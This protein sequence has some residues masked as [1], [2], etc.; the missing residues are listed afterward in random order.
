M[1]QIDESLYSRQLYVY[2]SDA[3]KTIT[4][5]TVLIH[6]ISGLSIEIAKNL[7][8]SGMNITF[9]DKEQKI[10]IDMIST[11][12]FL[13]EQDIDK[14]IDIIIPKLCELNSN[15]KVSFYKLD[16]II[17]Y[18]LLD[19][20]VYDIII[21]VSQNL[22]LEKINNQYIRTKNKKYI[23]CDSY[24]LFGSIFC[25]FGD[26]FN[27][28]DIDGEEIKSGVINNI[29][30]KIIETI[31]PHNLMTG[32]IIVFDDDINQQQIT[33]I[34]RNQFYV[35]SIKLNANRFTQIKKKEIKS[36]KNLQSSIDNPDINHIDFCNELKGKTI[37]EIYKLKF[38]NTF[39]NYSNY[40]QNSIDKFIEILK[41]NSNVDINLVQK[42]TK[43]L[44][45]NLV[46]INS[47]I[48]SIVAQEAIKACTGKYTPIYQWLHFEASDLLLENNHNIEYSNS[49]Y[50]NQEKIFGNEL[51]KIINNSKIFIVGSGA[52]GCEHLKNFS[53]MGC[54]L[55]VTDMDTI[56][57]SNLSRQF[58]F[59]NNDIGKLKSVVACNKA[60]QMNS[61]INIIAH[62]NKVE[63]NTLHIYNEQ[64]FND[65]TCVTNALDNISARLFVDSLCVMHKKPLI[66]SGTLG[67]KCNIQTII[68]Y[69]TESYGSSSDPP[70]ESIPI[71]TLKNFPYLI[72]HTIQWARELFEGLFTN[73]PLNVI[74]FIHD[75]NFLKN[76][77]SSELVIVVNEIK[78]I[79]SNIPSNFQKC[80]DIACNEFY[81]LFINQTINLLN[82][83]P[84][85]LMIN[86]IPFWSGSKKCPIII[87]FDIN[88][89]NHSNFIIN[90]AFLWA[91]LFNIKIDISDFDIMTYIKDKM[92]LMQFIDSSPL[93]FSANDE[94]EK[95]YQKELEENLNIEELIKSIPPFDSTI[96]IKPIEFEKDDDTNH[97]I[98][99]IT[100][101][102]NL[103]ASIYSIPVIDKFKTKGIAGKIIP[104]I[105]TT[106]SLVSGLVSIEL[107][108]II[109]KNNFINKLETY[110]NWFCNSALS[111]YG[112]SEPIIATK[113]QFGTNKISLWDS[114]IFNNPTINDLIIFFN[115]NYNL[116]ITTIVYEQI[117]LYSPL[118]MLKKQIERKSKSIQTIMNDLNVNI[119]SNPFQITILLTNDNDND[120]N[121]NDDIN[122]DKYIDITC[123]IYF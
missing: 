110:K 66:D 1:T 37:H 84:T 118:L 32:D 120:Y 99:F 93:H 34:N 119:I 51:Q 53:M 15:V 46:P 14:S 82:K 97:H 17:N 64:F 23:L 20:S 63:N 54:N 21:S 75:S 18:E 117:M 50:I 122:D 33:Y 59:R 16:T 109:L 38:T 61:S 40:N 45:G 43:C 115:D 88:N 69:L 114:F 49:R 106:T 91:T 113:K 52:I 67:T 78:K 83:F 41:N 31:E 68:P 29:S 10:T 92:Q 73:G 13:N 39:D 24:G 35:D 22:Y 58:L 86:N 4:S 9:I 94:E 26:I 87:Q 107:Y 105:A 47:I 11:N 5:T 3:M 27:I 108:K 72:E 103:R 101:V 71:C 65:I 36:F 76:L 85:D 111:Y 19:L 98:D 121:I 56:E 8:L 62:Q 12:Y 116:N 79:L 123:K 42:Y 81:N 95:K 28:N 48:G 44:D 25:D 80:L 70:E 30:D 6:G 89:E 77:P 112:F 74:K 2:G 55:I 100:S 102:S 57:R 104:A 7:I 90:F 60:K 96:Q